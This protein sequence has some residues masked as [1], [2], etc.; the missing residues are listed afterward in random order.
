MKRYADFYRLPALLML[1][2]MS[3]CE[4]PRPAPTSVS[5]P[6][7]VW[8][9]PPAEPRIAY[10][11]SFTGPTDMGIAPSRWRWLLNLVTG[12]GGKKEN[13]VKPF[14]VAFDEAGNIC[15]T[16][17]GAGVVAFFDQEE[18]SYTRWERVGRIRFS[19]PVAVAKAQGVFY[20]ADSGLKEIL[21][22]DRRGKLRFEIKQGLERPSG[23]AICNG[24]LYVADPVAHAV[25]VFDLDGKFSFRFGR[26]GADYGEFN[27]PTHITADAQKRILVTDS[28]NG[29]VQVFDTQGHFQASIGSSGD[30]LGQFG[31]PKGVA[32]DSAGHIYV[33]DALFDNIQ[34]FDL[35]GRL[36]MTWGEAGSAAGEFWLP[37]GL[38]INSA[39]EI[40]VADSYNQRIQVFKFLGAP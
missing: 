40:L 37:E 18:K 27:C 12:L 7:K 21:A 35:A 10:A 23:L 20:V 3:A 14:G 16:D 8:P 28:I 19:L 30:A 29:R 5:L 15:L 26:R 11:R 22:F 32:V 24:K 4:T 2:C 31:R 6:Q 36:L 9:P 25:V 1:L 17:T 13:L 39:N 38:A 33:A 34:V